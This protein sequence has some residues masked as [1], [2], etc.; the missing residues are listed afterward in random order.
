MPDPQGRLEK[1]LYLEERPDFP[2]LPWCQCPLI[3]WAPLGLSSGE[4]HDQFVWATAHTGNSQLLGA[5]G[6]RLIGNEYPL[7]NSHGL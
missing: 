1:E 7:E 4:E 5:A 3:L 2:G 6:G